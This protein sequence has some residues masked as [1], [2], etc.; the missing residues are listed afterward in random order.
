LRRH[1]H[2]IETI[3]F[4]RRERGAFRQAL[5]SSNEFHLAAI[6][7]TSE[8]MMART[9]AVALLEA[10]DDEARARPARSGEVPSPGIVL[11]VLT[12]VQDAKATGQAIE[13]KAIDAGE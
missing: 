6:R 12:V 8:N 7:N 9:K 1:L 3:A 5:C 4:I 2:R 13:A 11:R 10:I